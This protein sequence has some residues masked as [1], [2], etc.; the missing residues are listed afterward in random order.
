MHA[1]FFACIAKT[2]TEISVETMPCGE[3]SSGKTLRDVVLFYRTLSEPSGR[4]PEEPDRRVGVQAGKV[5]RCFLRI[6]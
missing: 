1:L 5:R 6:S 2:C 4:R 3:K